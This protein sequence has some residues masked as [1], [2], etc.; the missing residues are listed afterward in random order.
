M[1]EELATE[2]DRDMLKRILA[3]YLGLAVLAE[4]AA[5]RCLPIRL[6]VLW[7]LRRGEAV[8]LRRVAE[9]GSWPLYAS[10]AQRYDDSLSEAGRLARLFRAAAR[11]VR[12]QLRQI[13][14]SRPSNGAETSA[15]SECP[16]ASL[17]QSVVRS[18]GFMTLARERFD[19][20]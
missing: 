9:L 2:V 20:S 17:V 5:R 4:R 7:Y 3:L 15:S 6:L 12:K 19:S 1:N 11:A 10:L 18:A 8:A 14:R 13:A 16:M